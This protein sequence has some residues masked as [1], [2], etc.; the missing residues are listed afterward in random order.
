[1]PQ[2]TSTT[3]LRGGLN[4]VTPAIAVPPG[5]CI[6][7]LN[8]EPEVRGY[9]R[10]GGYERFDGRP[11]PSSASYWLLRFTGGMTGIA[12][13]NV[14]TGDTSGAT[15]KAL[16]DATVT[17]GSY[18]DDDAEGYL[19]LYA[20][21]GAFDDGEDLE[22]SAVKVAE[23]DGDAIEQGADN[24]EDDKLW[25][26][27]AIEAT[28]TPIAAVP[29]SGPVRGVWTYNGAVYA[30]RNNV[31]GTACIMHK[32]SPTGW[33]AQSF[34][35]T[36]AFNTG[37]T[38]F[39]EGETLTKGSVT[40]IIR[41]VVVTSGTWGTDD[42]VGYLVVSN[43]AGGSFTAGVATS[44]SG[45]A[46]LAGAQVAITLPAGGRYAFVNHNFYGAGKTD[47]MY[48][49]NGVGPAFM[50][51]GTY[52]TPIRTGL[53]DA[54]DK[55][56]RIAEFSNHLFLGYD[57]GEVQFSGLGEP[58]SFLAIDDA[59]SFTFGSKVTDM[60][61]SASSALVI[62]G[63]NRVSYLT[64]S[65]STDFV[66]SPLADDAGAVEWTAQ[67]IGNPVYQD[68]AGV[69]RMTT[70][71]AFGNWRMGTITEAITP[72]FKAKKKAGAVAVAS[73]RS[74][75]ADQ[76]RLF[77]SDKSGITIYMGR[78]MP[79]IL[80]FKLEIQ[81]TCSCAGPFDGV[82]DAEQLF[83]GDD[84]GFVY[85]MDVGTSFDGQQ[86]SAFMLL[87]F[88]A[89]GSPQQKKRFHKA[90]L[91]V[92]AGPDT[93]IAMSAEFGY[94]DPDQP[95]GQEQSF[96][97]SGSGGFWNNANWNEFYWSAPIQGIAEAYLD[98]V[99]RNVAIGILSDATYEEPHTLSALTFNFTYRGLVR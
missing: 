54:L 59:G 6:A 61:Q 42:A 46:T 25:L 60:L 75:A 40:A 53:T 77:M 98:G 45:S 52:L 93:Q 44:P 31:G 39:L 88:N 38:A 37:T 51:D 82:G 74:R 56:T 73:I 8:Y 15:G 4:L 7:A 76:Y 30:F 85:Q 50:W 66:L 21:T 22:V 10:I 34:G 43:I 26:R 92:D 27:A 90:T 1:M 47:R 12:A 80:P 2:L 62:F 63:R 99:G 13:G 49:C 87:P 19:I 14:V 78:K 11:R 58:L 81:V 86:I 64:G 96:D 48:G 69:R 20:V 91:E 57:N 67:M 71:Q 33:Q 94:G 17:S 29:G 84:Q 83:V 72:W 35:H 41:R 97:I 65:D 18:A 3:L 95:P 70:T 68:D 16:F 36:V 24:D 5:S 79:E 28:R 32:S 89:V 9:S 55:P 23:A